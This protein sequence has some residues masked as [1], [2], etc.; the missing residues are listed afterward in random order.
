MQLQLSGI[1]SYID[2][3][4]SSVAE[5][6]NEDIPKIHLTA[7]ETPWDPSMNK[8]SERETCMLDHPGEISIPATVARGPLFVSTVFSY[9]L[10]YD[11]TDVMDT[12]NLASAR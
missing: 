2:V 9:S 3:H 7:K 10:A 6:E 11:A 12:D 8:Y 1:T 5:Y 4:S